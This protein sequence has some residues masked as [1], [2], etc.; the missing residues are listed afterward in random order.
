MYCVANSQS[1]LLCCYVTAIQDVYTVCLVGEY[2]NPSEMERVPGPTPAVG[3][4][5][6]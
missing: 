3:G 2:I 4:A 5:H 1:R 6:P